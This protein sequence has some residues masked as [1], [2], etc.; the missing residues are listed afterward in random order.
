MALLVECKYLYYGLSKYLRA[1][2]TQWGVKEESLPQFH[3]ISPRGIQ[4]I[5][6]AM[7]GGVL[8]TIVVYSYKQQLNYGVIFHMKN[9]YCQNNKKILKSIDFTSNDIWLNVS[10]QRRTNMPILLLGSNI[11]WSSSIT[12]ESEPPKIPDRKKNKHRLSHFL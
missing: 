10:K 7:T 6:F 5:S 9:Q 3:R 11:I 12:L 2:G 1:H 4:C 8:K